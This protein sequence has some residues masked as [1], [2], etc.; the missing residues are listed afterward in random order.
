MKENFL[1]KELRIPIEGLLCRRVVQR[2]TEY[3]G[4]GIVFQLLWSDYSLQHAGLL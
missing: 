3:E 2:R 1:S 4:A